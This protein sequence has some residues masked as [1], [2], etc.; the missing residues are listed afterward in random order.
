MMNS[1]NRFPVRVG[2]MAALL[3][4]F[5]LLFI[6]YRTTGEIHYLIVSLIAAVVAIIVAPGRRR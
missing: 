6:D 1:R 2:L 3:V 4:V 5:L